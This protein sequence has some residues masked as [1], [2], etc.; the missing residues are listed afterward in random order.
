MKVMTKSSIKSISIGLKIHTSYIYLMEIFQL[1]AHLQ[2]FGS[3][4]GK[5]D[6]D[7]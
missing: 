5:S 6:E 7:A 3:N 4:E 2:D 1:P